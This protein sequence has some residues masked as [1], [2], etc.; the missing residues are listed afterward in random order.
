MDVYES[1]QP[2]N[3]TLI[4]RS[5]DNG[6]SWYYLSELMPCFW[7]KLFLHKGDVYMLSCSTEYGDLLIS[8]S[9]D[10]AKSF[11]SPTVL[12]RGSNGKAGNVGV[13]KN[14]QN[15]VIYNGR[16]YNT[17]EWGSWQNKEYYHAASV[18]SCGIDDDLCDPASW[19]FTPPLKY[20]PQWNGVSPD[21]FKGTIEGTLCVSPD[22]E[23]YNVMRYQ[24]GD[25]RA[26]VY[27]VDT[28]DHDAPLTFSHAIDFPGNLSKF[29]IKY[30]AESGKY[31]SI[32]CRR[33]DDPKTNRNLLSLISSTDLLCWKVDCDLIDKRFDDPK[34]VG[35]QYVDFD[36]DGDDIIFLCR[37][38]MNNADTFHNSNYSTFH[39]VKD[40]R[41]NN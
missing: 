7:G 25:K 21:G 38:A 4:F 13:H 2:Q 31:Y 32:V 14:P 23:L 34:K 24:T 40:F 3:L 9:N 30:D 8:R 19:H 18:M 15:I 26:L 20:D 1:G 12:L 22:G 39:R 37:T 6:E 27:K 10:G 29:M 11:A 16:L 28:E 33:I 5:D 35:F 17:F 36:F 41:K